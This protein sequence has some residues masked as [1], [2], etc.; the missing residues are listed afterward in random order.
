MHFRGS[1]AS[2]AS[3]A[4]LASLRSSNRTEDDVRD[5]SELVQ[6]AC[7]HEYA[8]VAALCGVADVSDA[9]PVAKSLLA[10]ALSHGDALEM[11]RCCLRV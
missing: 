7:A 2:M 11:V 1:S 8:L 5:Y 6:L 4:S 10:V 3:L 9:E